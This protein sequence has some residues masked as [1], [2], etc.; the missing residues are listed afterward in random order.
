LPDALPLA[1]MLSC[2]RAHVPAPFDS[3]GMN[4]YR[5]GNDSV[6]MHGDKLHVLRDAYPIVVFS[7]GAPR[8]MLIRPVDDHARRIAIDLM[9]GSLLAMSHAMQ[10]TH[11]HGIPKTRHA[12]PRISAVFRVRPGAQARSEAPAKPQ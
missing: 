6:A 12:A 11:E 9:P 2:V 3:I 4:F 7:L 1:D 8:R 5:D 10:T